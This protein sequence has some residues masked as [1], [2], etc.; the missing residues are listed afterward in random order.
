MHN[1]FDELELTIQCPVCHTNIK[2]RTGS[3]KRAGA[4][5]C[6]T[7]GR[8]NLSGQ[9]VQKLFAAIAETERSY[10]DL[11]RNLFFKLE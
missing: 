10:A 4:I 8:I 2:E 1:V 7:C 6:S 11:G 3:I 5:K 9:R